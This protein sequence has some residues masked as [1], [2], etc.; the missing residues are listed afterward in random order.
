VQRVGR[1]H[2]CIRSM[3]VIYQSVTPSTPSQRLPIT[4]HSSVRIVHISIRQPAAQVSQMCR[5]AC[6]VGQARMDAVGLGH[7]SSKD[8]MRTVPAPR[9]LT[10][11]FG[12]PCQWPR[13]EPPCAALPDRL[14]QVLFDACPHA[15]HANEPPP[16][17]AAPA[18]R[19]RT[20]P[21]PR[22][23]RPRRP[24]QPG[25]RCASW[26]DVQQAQ[27]MVDLRKVRTPRP[28]NAAQGLQSC[29]VTGDVP[30]I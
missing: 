20:P 2:T 4:F 22:V 23:G 29:R 27:A 16:S 5:R 19:G 28:M 30:E 13:G 8:A 15:A 3:L 11:R 18:C 24:H 6:S 21:P 25:I 26:S 10:V 12:A 17:Q 9:C 1:N 14:S 7:S